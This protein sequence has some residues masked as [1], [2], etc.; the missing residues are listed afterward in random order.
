MNAREITKTN[1]EDNGFRI[2]QSRGNKGT[3]IFKT[4]TLFISE[5]GI[6]N[7][8]S[9]GRSRLIEKLT[10]LN[11]DELYIYYI[12]FV[13]NHE[14]ITL[15]DLN[16]SNQPFSIQELLDSKFESIESISIYKKSKLL[17]F[18]SI[19]KYNTS[20]E[21]Q[22]QLIT[23]LYS[24]DN[25]NLLTAVDSWGCPDDEDAVIKF[26]R[27]GDH[28]MWCGDYHLYH[29]DSTY[30]VSTSTAR[31]FEGRV[32]DLNES[33]IDDFWSFQKDE[34]IEYISEL[35]PD[36]TI[37]VYS[38]KGKDWYVG[39]ALKTTSFCLTFIDDDELIE[40][41]N[42]EF[43]TYT[44]NTALTNQ[45]YEVLESYKKDISLKSVVR[46]YL[47]KRKDEIELIS[48][49]YSDIENFIL[50]SLEANEDVEFSESLVAIEYQ[51][52]VNESLKVK[53]DYTVEITKS[54]SCTA[55]EVTAYPY[56]KRLHKLGRRLNFEL[57]Q[58]AISN[59]DSISW[60]IKQDEEEYHFSL[61]E[62]IAN[63]EIE[64]YTFGEF[65]DEVLDALQKE[66]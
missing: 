7:E 3:E 59:N 37:C 18:H 26:T 61:I 57:V 35:D 49:F 29:S 6:N 13:K 2:G 21:D 39:Y 25:C 42:I 48:E 20:Y 52:I 46:N 28:E 62:M 38:R 24:M 27:H 4:R 56:F 36:D 58:S 34:M 53:E 50:E 8:G 45:V 65:V 15:T 55:D 64:K 33:T 16:L 40:G 43:L 31:F 12:K 32:Y 5:Y 9:K 63:L 22:K 23:E 14:L 11:L 51:K 47:E 30:C 17:G 41:E 19:S 10:G 60:A 66:N 54:F 1:I 44:E